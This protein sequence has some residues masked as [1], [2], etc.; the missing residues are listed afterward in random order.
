MLTKMNPFQNL[1]MY[2]PAETQV[3]DPW[4]NEFSNELLP[5]FKYGKINL[6][7]TRV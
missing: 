1:I 2:N 5:Q 7:V 3:I 6:S 4:I